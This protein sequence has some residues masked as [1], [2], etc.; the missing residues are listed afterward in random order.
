[1]PNHIAFAAARDCQPCGMRASVAYGDLPRRRPL[2]AEIWAQP[3]RQA[4][5]RTHSC[6]TV[7]QLG[8]RHRS[9]MG[10][11]VNGRTRVSPGR[12]TGYR[13]TGQVRSRPSSSPRDLSCEDP[14]RVPSM[15]GIAPGASVTDAA[16]PASCGVAP[17][18]WAR[19]WGAVPGDRLAPILAR[20]LPGPPRR[21]RTGRRS[22]PYARA[23]QLV[24]DRVTP[25]RSASP[26]PGAAWRGATRF[27]DQAHADRC[28]ARGRNPRRG[29]GR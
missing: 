21:K 24:L 15:V 6:G 17:G 27:D 4:I 29:A 20:R 7:A 11:A 1:M 10:L 18:A 5:I 19:T 2:P 28:H 9:G 8:A 23:A 3:R 25:P 22:L 14:W 13:P 16:S 12:R 26:H